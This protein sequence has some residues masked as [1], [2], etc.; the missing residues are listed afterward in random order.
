MSL[1]PGFI[2]VW[3]CGFRN[4]TL[5]ELFSQGCMHQIIL[6]YLNRPA[7][8]SCAPGENRFICMP[9]CTKCYVFVMWLFLGSTGIANLNDEINF[10]F[11]LCSASCFFSCH[12][13]TIYMHINKDIFYYVIE[14]ELSTFNKRKIQSNF[15]IFV[16]PLQTMTHWSI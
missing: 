7:F 3:V 13:L 16:L 12:H 5:L 8:L 1:L 15:I 6:G 14:P 11:V 9:A 4:M 2:A 10:W